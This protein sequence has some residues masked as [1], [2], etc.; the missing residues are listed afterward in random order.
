[1]LGKN[2]EIMSLMMKNKDISLKELMKAYG[3]YA[4]RQG[5]K[6]KYNATQL[7]YMICEIVD[8]TTWLSKSNN[9]DTDRVLEA[10]KHLCKFYKTSEKYI[11][12]YSDKSKVFLIDNEKVP[13]VFLSYLADLLIRLSMYV[14]ANDWTDAFIEI[15]HNKLMND[16]AYDITDIG[17]FNNRRLGWKK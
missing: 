5:L 11:T 10:I 7:L 6:P 1:M 4:K 14:G 3:D 13:M 12:N 9:S 2:S 17:R 15:L 16:E 8:A